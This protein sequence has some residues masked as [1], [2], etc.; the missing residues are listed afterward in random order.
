MIYEAINHK[1]VDLVGLSPAKILDLGCG[2]GALGR[3][4]KSRAGHDITGITY[5]NEEGMVANEIL[6]QVIVADLNYLA[7]EE[8]GQFDLIICS[9]VLEHLNDP[10]SL[11]LRLRYCLR[12]GGRL[13]VALPNV[14]WWKQRWEFLLGRFRYTDGGLMDRTH[15][16]FFDHETAQSLLMEAGY[17][18]NHFEAEGN[19]PLPVLRKVLPPKYSTQLDT[20][21][22]RSWPGLFGWQFLLV[23]QSL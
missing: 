5:S 23:G 15:C 22:V 13:I 11:L 8:L 4:L 3:V 2:S 6:D 12:E 14:L 16:R 10:G 21:A 7:T 18:I 19:F 20:W 17:Q 9:H 1:V